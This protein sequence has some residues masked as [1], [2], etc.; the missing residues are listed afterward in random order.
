M[1]VSGTS[2]TLSKAL[3]RGILAAGILVASRGAA[4]SGAGELLFRSAL[5][6][7]KA[8]SEDIARGQDLPNKKVEPQVAQ[9]PKQNPH[10]QGGNKVNIKA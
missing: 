8:A 2:S 5:S 1:A 9:D 10:P 4:A 7:A 3:F 6:G